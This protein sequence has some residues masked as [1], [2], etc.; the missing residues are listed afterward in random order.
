MRK[1]GAIVFGFNEYAKEIAMQ[2]APEYSSFVVYVMN[3]TE[4]ASA[5]TRGFETEIFDLS[6]EWRSIEERFDPDSL[7]VFCALDNDA[8]NVFLTISLRSVFEDLT[9]I[10]LAQDNESAAKLKSAG[11][12]KVLATQQITAG[13]IDEM[14][15]KPTVREVLHD[16]LYENSALKIVQLAVP[17]GSFLVGKHL[18]DI[19]WA[20]EYDVLVLA[21]VDQEL[22]ATFSFTSKGH[23]HHIDPHDLLIVAGYEDKIA[24]LSDAMGEKR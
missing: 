14:L 24:A 12:N 8:E 6:E 2:I 15:E 11:A 21:I 3:D 23:N 7:I 1:K 17:E 16:I 19:D 22:S 5:E 18:Y 4:K 10:A 20:G 13:I 9:I